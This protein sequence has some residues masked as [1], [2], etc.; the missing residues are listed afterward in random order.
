MT[1]RL[2]EMNG[3]TLQVIAELSH[4]SKAALS[5]W[6]RSQYKGNTANVA[7]AVNECLDQLERMANAASSPTPEEVS[8]RSAASPKSSRAERMKR[9]RQE[10]EAEEAAFIIQPRSPKAMS[11]SDNGSGAQLPSPVHADDI[12]SVCGSD[13][14]APRS[15][16]ATRTLSLMSE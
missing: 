14:A 3:V 12:A 10:A 13:V 4:Y 5:L 8:S 6:R 1:S 7:I 11:L 2:S 9:K 15:V 16:E